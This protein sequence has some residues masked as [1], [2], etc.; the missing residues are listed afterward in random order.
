[1]KLPTGDRL[2]HSALACYPRDWRARHAREAAELAAQLAAEGTAPVS[3]AWSYLVGAGRIRA[4]RQG[5][6]RRA[7]LV[8]ALSAA[9][10]LVGGL[11]LADLS[12]Q[13][14]AVGVVQVRLVAHGGTV[15]RLAADLAARGLAARVVARPTGPDRAGTVLAVRWAVPLPGQPPVAPVHGPCP[16]GHGTCTIGLSLPA[17]LSA[18]LEV[19]VGT[20][21]APGAGR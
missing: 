11:G 15:H 17:H 16:G 10:L 21:T 12:A 14:G 19:V 5:R 2:V 6:L 3:I 7:V 18:P 8:G 1:V 20:S 4:T 13:A 9:P